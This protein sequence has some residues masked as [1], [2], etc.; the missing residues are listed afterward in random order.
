MYNIIVSHSYRN[1][2]NS[3]T[4]VPKNVEIL[5][6]SH[7][8][9]STVENNC[10]NVSRFP[11]YAFEY[12]LS[13]CFVYLKGYTYLQQLFISHNYVQLIYLEAFQNMK[14][15]T[16]IDLSYNRI[17]ELDNRIFLENPALL[18]LDLSGN[19][20]MSFSDKPLILSDSLKVIIIS[21]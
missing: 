19:K 18:E 5:D 8:K 4:E 1:L 11:I 3:N 20:F 14:R 13:E 2:I 12:Y 9:I 16:M 17:E 6:L 7:N 10:F 15:L 21:K